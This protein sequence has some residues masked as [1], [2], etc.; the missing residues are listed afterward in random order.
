MS[1]TPSNPSRV[2]MR[3]T[4]ITKQT[5]DRGHSRAKLGVTMYKHDV[6]SPSATTEM[7]ESDLFDGCLCAV[8]LEHRL[9]LLRVLLGQSPFDDRGSLL[10]K[11]F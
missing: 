9:E 8:G 1:S 7:S 3:V 11:L 5:F 4:R 10:H 2:T 6:M